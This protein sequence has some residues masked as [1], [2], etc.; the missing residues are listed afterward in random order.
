MQVGDDRVGAP[1]HD[2]PAVD[3]LLGI[4][5]GAGADRGREAGRCHGAADI[6]IEIAASHRSEQTR[7]EG[8]L[9]NQPL[10]ARRAV[11]QDRLSARFVDDGLPSRCDV[12][13][14]LV[15]T[16]AFELPLTLPA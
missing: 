5:P 7:V 10:D 11:R 1:Q 3:D 12:P 2:V 13:E 16:D 9:L 4:D 6:A 14:R 15:P 8:R